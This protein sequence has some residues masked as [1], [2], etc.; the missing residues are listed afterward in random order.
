M[1]PSR[2]LMLGLVL[3]L[4]GSVFGMEN[5]YEQYDSMDA[6]NNYVKHSGEHSYEIAASFKKALGI[7]GGKEDGTTNDAPGVAKNL[8]EAD[9][10]RSNLKQFLKYAITIVLFVLMLCFVGSFAKSAIK[11][12]L[13]VLLVAGCFLFL[14]YHLGLFS[15]EPVDEIK[16][17]LMN[18]VDKMLKT[19]PDERTKFATEHKN[20][21]LNAAYSAWKT[22][23]NV[24]EA[25]TE[26]LLN[27]AYDAPTETHNVHENGAHSNSYA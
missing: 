17:G 15:Q 24:L 25:P 21:L 11:V 8:P 9:Q 20:K 1:N 12:V 16:N 5:E 4:S 7:L 26:G 10:K 22:I 19:T 27:Y 13:K 6:E 2:L 18:G 14:A 3:L 23:D